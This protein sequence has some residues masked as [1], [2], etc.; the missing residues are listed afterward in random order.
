MCFVR[1]INWHKGGW[2]STWKIHSHRNKGTFGY[3]VHICI[4]IL[5]L[6]PSQTLPFTRGSG[7]RTHKNNPTSSHSMP[8]HHHIRI[9]PPL[10][11][12]LQLL[13][14]GE[15]WTYIV[16]HKY[17]WA[18]TFVRISGSLCKI[19]LRQIA[20]F[21]HNS[22]RNPKRQIFFTHYLL[23]ICARWPLL[24]FVGLLN[25]YLPMN[26]LPPCCCF[27]HAPCHTMTI[28]LKGRI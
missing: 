13:R 21:A 6:V 20:Q 11:F 24:L 18:H 17:R 15:W 4:I 23:I 16:K 28:T 3:G 5:I 22:V 26:F 9:I 1:L 25:G 12:W 2:T 8:P 7:R 14:W 10:L 19:L 27:S